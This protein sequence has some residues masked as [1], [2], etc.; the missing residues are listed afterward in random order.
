MA[1]TPVNG[2][3]P[4][5]PSSIFKAP[6]T[7]RFEQRG[8]FASNPVNQR[9]EGVGCLQDYES[10]ANDSQNASKRN[11]QEGSSYQLETPGHKIKIKKSVLALNSTRSHNQN[12]G[13]R[14][15]LNCN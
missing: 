12:T 7:T 14:E 1:T 13:D 5:E 2:I 3:T 10:I 15:A 11:N 8:T 6:K 9:S 4:R